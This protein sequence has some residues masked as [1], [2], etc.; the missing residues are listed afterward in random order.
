MSSGLFTRPVRMTALLTVLLP[1]FVFTSAFSFAPT[2]ARRAAAQTT[3]IV[4]SEGDPRTDLAPV[5]PASPPLGTAPAI[6]IVNLPDRPLRPRLILLTDLG[7]SPHREQQLVHLLTVCDRMD[8]EGLIAVTSDQ[9]PGPPQPER[10][11]PFI[12]AFEQVVPNL[13]KHSEGW[14]TAEQLRAVVAAGQS[15]FGLR[16]LGDG[17]SSPGSE[18][19]VSA[20]IRDDPRPL[21]IAVVGG[22]NTLGQALLDLRSRFIDSEFE[23]ML[24][25][26]RVYESGARDPASAWICRDW[27][28]IH[29]VRSLSQA[30]GLAEGAITEDTPMWLRRMSVQTPGPWC[31]EPFVEDA[32]GQNAWVKENIQKDHGP[33][34]KV[35]PD[36]QPP[37][38]RPRCI[39]GGG[40]ATWIG[41]VNTG[42]YDSGRP[43]WGGW[44]GRFS[45]MK[46][47]DEQ[48]LDPETQ[49]SEQAFFPF[50]MY[51]QASDTWTDPRTQTSY[52]GD[53]VPIWRF[54]RSIWNDLAARMDWCV[55]PYDQA[56]HHPIAAVNGDTT[57]RILTQWAEAGDRIELTATASTDPDGDPLTYRWWIYPEAGTYPGT[58][59]IENADQPRI[60]L[61]VPDGA[62]GSEIHL[63]L[64]VSDQRKQSPE[65]TSYRR[66][67]VT[68][69]DG[70]IEN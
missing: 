60:F 51:R 25:N 44:G 14:M 1:T 48:S 6:P 20:M 38:I 50:M 34:G 31:W 69:A 41:L 40:A 18:R 2:A 62:E 7:A 66:I 49:V 65:L 59:T 52:Q 56:N 43:W 57:G 11:A 19:I 16:N 27:P 22:S 28:K 35:Y 63:V 53:L 32:A 33:L 45:R 3:G 24:A 23:A 36:S 8:I 26:V 70:G 17:R 67:V 21:H 61:T 37:G 5:L 4:E 12:D 42:L 10:F 15:D 55:K 68:V 54:R 58:V 46:V 13:R 47:S 29:W 64:E 9:L 39:E 30:Y